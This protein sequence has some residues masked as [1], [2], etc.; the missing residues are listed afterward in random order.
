MLK[1]IKYFIINNTAKFIFKKKVLNEYFHTIHNFC[2]FFTNA[3]TLTDFVEMLLVLVE[4]HSYL[5]ILV[6]YK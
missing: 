3:I 1:K 4:K 6:V 5:S 2:M